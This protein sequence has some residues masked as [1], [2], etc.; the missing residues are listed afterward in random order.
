MKDLLKGVDNV[1][2]KAIILGGNLNLVFYCNLEACSGNPAL[3]NKS[4]TKFIEI[5][6]SVNLCSIWRIRNPKFKRYTFR[7]NHSS[8]FIQRRL[9]YIFFVK[10]FTGT[11]EKKLIF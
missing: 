8:G 2:D 10:C 9:D 1:S 3:K 6:E 7:Q 4:P 5:K 11:R